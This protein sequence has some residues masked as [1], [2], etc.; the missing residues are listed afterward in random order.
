[1]DV[2]VV[3]IMPTLMERQLDPAAGYLLAEAVKAR[4]I[5][6]MTSANT[7]Q[8][9]GETRV[10][11]VELADGTILPADLVVMAVGIRPNAALA[12]DAGLAVNR[13]IVVDAQMRTSDP[14]IYA[15]G[16]C[17][18]VEG[19][20]FGLVA[21]LYEMAGSSPPGFSASRPSSFRSRPRPAQGH[22]H[23]PL[24][25]RRFR[26]GRGSRGD[27]AARRQCRRLQAPGARARSH[28][29]R[30][31]LRRYRRWRLVLRHAAQGHRHPC[32][33]R[34]LI[35]GQAYQGGPAGPY[36][37]RCSLAG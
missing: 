36:G 21:P 12:R 32:L 25:R 3:H 34:H 14:A 1:M 27:R 6:V 8:I 7:R 16:E 22:R 10:T 18:E 19:Q 28:R 11:G 13:G 2:T 9:V 23:Q 29:R 4:G 30:G 24:F 33:A 31:P 20:V 5:K 15:L 26:R 37:G 35:F 17:A